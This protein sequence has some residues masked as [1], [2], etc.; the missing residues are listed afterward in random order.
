[1]PLAFVSGDQRMYFFNP[2]VINL[3]EYENRVRT[4]VD[5]LKKYAYCLIFM[6]KSED[7]PVFM[8]FMI[9]LENLSSFY[10]SY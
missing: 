8:Y 2:H 1:M 5:K 4:A 6:S 3:K 7:V 10:K 9:Y